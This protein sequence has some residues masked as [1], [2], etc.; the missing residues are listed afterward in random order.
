VWNSAGLL[1]RRLVL[2]RGTLVMEVSRTY[3]AAGLPVEERTVSGGSLVVQTWT[4][5]ED[6]TTAAHA[7]V[8][9]GVTTLSESFTYEDGKVRTR[10]VTT[11]DA[12][13]SITTTTYGPTGEAVLVETRGADGALLS[14]TV[15]DR[16]PLP[17][18]PAKLAIKVSGGVATSSDVQ[19]T[20]M[21]AGFAIT[22]DP[23]PSTYDRDPIE[24]AITGSYLRSSSAGELTN[25]Q[26]D[27]RVG[28]DYNELVGPLTAFV[29]TQMSRNPVANLDIDLLAAPIGFKY[30]FVETPVFV[31]DASFAP[32]WNFRSITIGAGDVCEAGE[33]TEDAH[34]AFSKLRGSLRVRATL[35]NSVVKVKDTLE[36][37]P[38]LD[39]GGNFFTKVED[40]AILRNTLT[41]DVRLTSHF[42]L[43]ESIVFTRDPL[44]AAQAECTARS[45]ELLCQGMSLQTGSQLSLWY[46]F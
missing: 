21:T 10:T 37:L 3:D 17:F 6:G 43:S 9:D 42:G 1:T 2:D 27:G 4:Y 8:A 32:V 23:P 46:Q 36:F 14:R 20:A 5:N 44:L 19:T 31:F 38:T 35:G 33:V 34:C 39:G 12:G 13:T 22:R 40:E 25:D 28:V 15:S 16:E 7:V 45:E 24:L 30:T 11:P 41:L 18:T 26:L 29:F